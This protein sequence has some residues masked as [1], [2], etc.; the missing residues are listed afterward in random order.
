MTVVERMAPS[1]GVRV[2][3]LKL[4]IASRGCIAVNMQIS[5]TEEEDSFSRS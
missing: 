2:S 5:E 1:R 3:G 4:G